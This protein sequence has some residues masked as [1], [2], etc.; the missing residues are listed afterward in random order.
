[1]GVLSLLT[2]LIATASGEVMRDEPSEGSDQI[3]IGRERELADFARVLQEWCQRKS[4]QQKSEQLIPATGPSPQ[5]KLEG[6]LVLLYGHGGYG[7]TT[8]LKRYHAVACQLQQKASR[9]DAL[10]PG[11]AAHQKV[12]KL[13][14][15]EIIDWEFAVGEYRGLFHA[16]ARQEPDAVP[17]FHLLS[18]RLAEALQKRPDEFRLYQQAIQN[19]EDAHRQ[20]QRA[21]EELKASKGYEALGSISGE[22]AL[23]AIRLVA[24]RVGQVLD[25]THLDD[26]VK[27]VIGTGARIGAEQIKHIY[28]RLHAKLGTKLDD[29]LDPALCLGLALGA[30]LR[31]FARK[32]P[33]LLFFDTYEVTAEGDR[34]LRIVMAGAG[35][36]VGW[37]LAG[38][39]DLYADPLRGIGP[40]YNYRDVTTTGLVLHVNFSERGTG[41]FGI[42]DID[43]YFARLC[44]QP[45]EPEPLPAITLAEASQILHATLGVPLAVQI[46]AGIYKETAQVSAIL[47]AAEGSRQ[48]DLVGA[49]VRRYLVHVGDDPT[50]RAKLYGLAL[51]RRADQTDAIAAALGLT[52]AQAASG[53]YHRELIR[54]HRRYSFIFTEKDQPALHQEVRHFLRLELRKGECRQPEIKAAIR[55]LEMAHKAALTQLEQDRPYRSF[56]ERLQ[57]EEWVGVYLDLTEQ[58]FWLNPDEGVRYALPLLIVATIYRR[59]VFREVAQVGEF[60]QQQL[61]EPYQ[62]WWQVA[63]GGV[64]LLKEQPALLEELTQSIKQGRLAFLPPLP[65]GSNELE[66]TLWWRLGEVCRLQEDDQALEWFQKALTR[67]EKEKELRAAAAGT[68]RDVAYRRATAGKYAEAIPLLDQAIGLDADNPYTYYNRGLAYCLKRSEKD[69]QTANFTRAIADFTQALRLDMSF[70]AAYFSRGSA[71]F[72]LGELRSA[73]GEQEQAREEYEQACEDYK[74]ALNYDPNDARSCTNLGLTYGKLEDHEQA[75]YYLDL[76]ARLDPELRHNR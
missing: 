20:T 45:R 53:D 63:T 33:I 16:S 17:Y 70:A 39:D 56:K 2:R 3:F 1:L 41:A 52:P 22:V 64:A 37:V 23:Q 11:R 71:H 38:R 10:V 28:D 58:K 18:R 61:M 15:G 72:H 73:L 51:A 44:E 48:H 62:R 5:Q 69:E 6:L 24:P 30:D 34:L 19:V 8:L 74:Q 25:A 9:L 12:S 43:Q 36:Q 65:A 35:P 50:E 7:K 40:V 75:S 47:E 31:D 14:V 57:E 26:Q 76:A 68:S 4:R 49:M 60:F 46:A 29:S 21:L 27:A 66:G 54:L 67:L 13:N 59:E 55:R 32:V 42:D